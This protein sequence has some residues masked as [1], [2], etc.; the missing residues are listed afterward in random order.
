MI[1]QCCTNYERMEVGWTGRKIPLCGSFATRST[2]GKSLP[3]FKRSSRLMA[4][5]LSLSDILVTAGDFRSA[6]GVL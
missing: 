2:T 3:N 6:D 1:D 5:D 4:V